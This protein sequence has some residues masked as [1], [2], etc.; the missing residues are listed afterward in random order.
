MKRFLVLLSTIVV[1]VV[2][3]PAA[4]SA[5]PQPDVGVL[6]CSAGGQARV[7]LVA[8]GVLSF[9]SVG[10][11]NINR[12]VKRLEACPWSGILSTEYGNY[13]FCDWDDFPLPSI[14]AYW[15]YLNATKPARCL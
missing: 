10:R 2:G 4:A 15:I 7:T 5:A 6:A 14:T 8:G 9:N 11:H 13:L 12:S 3:V 1:G